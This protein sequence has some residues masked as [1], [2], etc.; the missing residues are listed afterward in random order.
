MSIQNFPL[1]S[2][3]KVRKYIKNS[4]LLTESETH[5]SVA[6]RTDDIPEPESIDALSGI[7]SFGTS[8]LVDTSALSAAEKW[9]I[10]TV[11]PAAPL[12]KLPGLKLKPG[13]RLV[14]Y[15]YRTEKSGL[16]VVWAVP[17]TLG[18]TSQ[19]E[20]SLKGSNTM[21]NVP[22]PDGALEHFMEAI[23]GDRSAVS[24]MVAS[25]LRRELQEFGSLGDRHNWNHHELIADVP[26]N[27]SWQWQVELPK[28]FLPK[29]RIFPD[30]QA[31]VEFFTCCRTVPITLYRHL[32]RYPAEQYRGD[33]L[34]KSLAVAHSK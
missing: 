12:L 25:L 21:A 30:G 5:P 19:L 24:F 29:V 13:F 10:S 9:F 8:S 18:T 15:L 23:E 14:S 7:F 3:Q 1:A 32:D 26:P 16:G 11:N 27:V 28:N 31:A 4:L 33:S 22:K 2:I 34:D 6:V 20:A 17:E